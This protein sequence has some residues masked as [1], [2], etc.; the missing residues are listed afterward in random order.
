MT[1][2]IDDGV[3]ER[4]EAKIVRTE[5][6]WFWTAYR[7]RKGYGTIGVRGKVRK[8]HRVAYELYVGPIPDGLTIDHLCRVRHCVNPAHLEPVPMSVNTLRGESDAAKAARRTHCLYGH[9][10]DRFVSGQRRC[11][12]CERERSARRRAGR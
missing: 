6:C 10:Y 1:R 11:S 4:L 9:P 3:R 12:T 2:L 8:A 5:T 7:D